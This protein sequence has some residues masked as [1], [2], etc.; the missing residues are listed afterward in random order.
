MPER[1]V[2]KCVPAFCS[3]KA[4]DFKFQVELRIDQS[5]LGGMAVVHMGAAKPWWATT[6]AFHD[7]AHPEYLYLHTWVGCTREHVGE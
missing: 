5:A 3:K 2:W 7:A 4:S 1:V 6:F